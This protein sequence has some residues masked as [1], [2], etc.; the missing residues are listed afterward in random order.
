[1]LE[2]VGANR[3]LITL[4]I[5]LGGRGDVCVNED[6]QTGVPRVGLFLQLKSTRYSLE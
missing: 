2:D 5:I 6:P 1:M 4:L 3:Q